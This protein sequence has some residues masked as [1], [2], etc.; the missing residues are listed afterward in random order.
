MQ[1]SLLGGGLLPLSSGR[2]FVRR[3]N[4]RLL[5][6]FCLDEQGAHIVE[7]T[8]LTALIILATYAVM[9]QLREQLAHVFR[10]LILR[11]FSVAGP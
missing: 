3:R 5:R 1:S 2:A 8:V 7:W 6:E 10:S 9:V 11:Q 4:L